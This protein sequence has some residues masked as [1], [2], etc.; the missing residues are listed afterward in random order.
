MLESPESGWFCSTPSVWVAIPHS[1]FKLLMSLGLSQQLCSSASPTQLEAAIPLL[2]WDLHPLLVKVYGAKS[3]LGCSAW[4]LSLPLCCKISSQWL[5]HQ[6]AVRGVSWSCSF[7]AAVGRA[8]GRWLCISQAELGKLFVCF[9]VFLLCFPWESVVCF[10][11]S[12][13][14]NSRMCCQNRDLLEMIRI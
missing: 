5:F 7:P 11:M 9:L 2:S 10:E 14:I 6:C 4:A 1:C 8:V 12:A 3:A 13:F